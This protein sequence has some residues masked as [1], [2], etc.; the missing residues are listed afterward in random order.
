MNSS[1]VQQNFGGLMS[2]Q[3]AMLTGN[4]YKV[5]PAHCPNHIQ[6][7]VPK[8]QLMIQSQQACTATARSC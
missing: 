2:P 7:A 8:L 5:L 4:T 6:K 1:T 3:Q